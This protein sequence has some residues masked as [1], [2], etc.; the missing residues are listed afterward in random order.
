MATTQKQNVSGTNVV[1][2]E[3]ELQR[4]LSHRTFDSGTEKAVLLLRVPTDVAETPVP[5]TVWSP[6]DDVVDAEAGTRIHVVA[7]VRQSSWT[8]DDGTRQYCTDIV[9]SDNGVSILDDRPG[10][11][12]DRRPQHANQAATAPTPRNNTQRRNPRR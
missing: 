5:V 3:G 8:T 1:E 9:A 4:V 11:G 7:N 2:L 12:N 10:R 6:T